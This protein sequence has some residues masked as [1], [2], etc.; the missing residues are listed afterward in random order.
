MADEP[1]NSVLEY[2]RHIRR[3]VDKLDTRVEKIENEFTQVQVAHHLVRGDDGARHGADRPSAGAN[4]KPDP[5]HRS[6]RGAA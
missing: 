6:N 3:M 1:D 4:R 2:L 5:R